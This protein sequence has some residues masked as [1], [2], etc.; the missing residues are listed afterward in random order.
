MLELLSSGQLLS[1]L[2]IS[3]LHVTC[4]W[5]FITQKIKWKYFVKITFYSTNQ[6]KHGTNSTIMECL[7]KSILSLCEAQT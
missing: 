3:N 6:H 1:G 7:M 2:G 4:L 5:P